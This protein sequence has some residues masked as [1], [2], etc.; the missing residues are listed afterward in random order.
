M[1]STLEQEADWGRRGREEEHYN[2]EQGSLVRRPWHRELD[3]MGTSAAIQMLDE[4]V[5]NK[6]KGL[7]F[8]PDN[9]E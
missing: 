6:E 9:L 3:M 2:S 4:P 7:F 1:G 8:E 5:A